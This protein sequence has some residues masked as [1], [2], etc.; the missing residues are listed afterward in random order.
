MKVTFAMTPRLP[1]DI[2]RALAQHRVY[3]DGLRGAAIA[4]LHE[5]SVCTVS[6]AR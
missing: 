1:I 4:Y 2:G 6:A 3:H 5:R